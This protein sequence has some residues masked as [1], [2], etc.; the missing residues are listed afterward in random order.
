MLRIWLTIEEE[1]AVP[2]LA[3]LAY[4]MCRRGV[5]RLTG[6]DV[7]ELLDRLRTDFPNIRAVRRRAPQAFL[8]MLEARSS[9]LI[10]SGGIWQKEGPQERV[11]LARPG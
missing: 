9:L 3:Y 7:L 10:K 11:F 4:E 2:Q 8:E 1:E 6:E 5:Q